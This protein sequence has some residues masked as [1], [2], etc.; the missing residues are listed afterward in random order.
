[1]VLLVGKLLGWIMIKSQNL[2]RQIQT[3]LLQVPNSCWVESSNSGWTASFSRNKP[4][5][6]PLSSRSVQEPYQGEA[7]FAK[8]AANN[9]VEGFLL[10]PAGGNDCIL[11]YWGSFWQQQTWLRI[12]PCHFDPKWDW[13]HL[14]E[15]MHL[16]VRSSCHLTPFDLISI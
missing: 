2:V 14:V 1:M 7:T 11:I 12:P 9:T 5:S 6:I 4:I 16:G 15:S 10:D 13:K 3:K 8:C